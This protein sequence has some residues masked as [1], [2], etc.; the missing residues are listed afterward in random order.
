M[1]VQLPDPI[2]NIKNA[3]I[4]AVVIIVVAIIGYLAYTKSLLQTQ[5]AQQQ[6]EIEQYKTA[7]DDWARANAQQDAAI[8][9][10]KTLSNTRAEAAAKALA[11]S[12]SKA[13]GFSALA[14]TLLKQKPAGA[15]CAATKKFLSDYFAGQP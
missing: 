14:D 11:A 7:N 2:S 4:I 9:N 13:K 8:K 15:D 10:L 5:V 12:Q 3:L 1:T 6:G